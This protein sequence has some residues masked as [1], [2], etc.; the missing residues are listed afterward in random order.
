MQF[1]GVGRGDDIVI[2][3][4]DQQRDVFRPLLQVVINGDDP[5]AVAMGQATD[6]GARFSKV[7]AQRD[8]GDVD[9]PGQNVQPALRFL[10]RRTIIDQD[11]FEAGAYRIPKHRFQSFDQ[12]NQ[13]STA[14][15]YGDDH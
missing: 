7:S 14:I 8:D 2:A 11:D 4:F 13:L 1:L 5:G 3:Q 10:A 6:D 12:F 15:E 9:F